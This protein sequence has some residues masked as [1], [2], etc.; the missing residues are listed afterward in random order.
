MSKWKTVAITMDDLF[1]EVSKYKEK[2]VE[3]DD[4]LNAR[5]KLIDSQRRKIMDLRDFKYS[6]QS[7]IDQLQFDSEL[8]KDQVL[9]LSAEKKS[10]NLLILEKQKEL[11]DKDELLENSKKDFK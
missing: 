9:E 8:E 5:D 2:I 10:L 1:E 6:L 4:A 7:Q 11:N 3:L